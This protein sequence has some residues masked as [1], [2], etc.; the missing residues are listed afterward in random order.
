MPD[1]WSGRVE[2]LCSAPLC[3]PGFQA[4]RQAL[5]DFAEGR[6][7]CVAWEFQ[8]W[9]KSSILNSMIDNFRVLSDISNI[10]VHEMPLQKK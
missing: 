9:W 3:T 8:P 4:A 2:Q 1:V 5:F 10:P 7:C 6:E